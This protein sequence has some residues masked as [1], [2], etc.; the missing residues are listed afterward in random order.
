MRKDAKIDHDH[1]THL[2]RF[3]TY[4]RVWEVLT[5]D[6]LFMPRPASFNDRFDCKVKFQQQDLKW[7]SEAQAKIDTCSRVLCFSAVQ[8]QDNLL[9]WAHYADGHRGVCLEFDMCQWLKH[10]KE[11]DKVK[12]WG[13]VLRKVQYDTTRL[14]VDLGAPTDLDGTPNL[15]LLFDII[16]RKHQHW[17]Y[18]QEW[19]L[20]YAGMAHSDVYYVRFPKKVLAKSLPRIKND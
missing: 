16:Y 15:E 7:E 3:L 17:K 13:Y 14:E 11:Q 6:K 18:E 5:L 1:P 9:M 20:Y 10:L 12:F 8:P 4:D 2:Y 19:R